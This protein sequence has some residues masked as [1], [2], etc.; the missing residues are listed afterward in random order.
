MSNTNPIYCKYQPRTPLGKRLTELRLR[1][2]EEGMRL[3][4]WDEIDQLV[5]RIRFENDHG[6]NPEPTVTGT[7]CED[8]TRSRSAK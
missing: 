4:T 5:G 8:G 1:A 7:P 3:L 2:I 6:R